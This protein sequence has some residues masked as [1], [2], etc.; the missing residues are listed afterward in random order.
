MY[1]NNSI[2][3]LIEGF[4]FCNLNGIR[5][6]KSEKKVKEEEKEREKKDNSNRGFLQNDRKPIE[7][8]YMLTFL[9]LYLIVILT[10]G[11]LK[12]H[13]IISGSINL[14]GKSAT[15]LSPL[16]LFIIDLFI[17][18]ISGDWDDSSTPYNLSILRI[19]KGPNFNYLLSFLFE[20]MNYNIIEAILL[21][22]KFDKINPNFIFLLQM[23]LLHDFVKIS[24]YL[25][26]L[27]MSFLNYG[28]ITT[29]SFKMNCLYDCK[30]LLK[31]L[32]LT[33]I[34]N[35]EK[36]SFK[37]FDGT[38]KPEIPLILSVKGQLSHLDLRIKRREI[39]QSGCSE[40]MNKDELYKFLNDLYKL[41]INEIGKKI[42]GK[43]KGL[44]SDIA[45]NYNFLRYIMKEKFGVAFF[46]FLKIGWMDITLKE[47]K[48]LLQSNMSENK[49]IY[50]GQLNDSF[51]TPDDI[52]MLRFFVQRH[53][54][55]YALNNP[56]ENS[57]A[58]IIER[59]FTLNLSDVSHRFTE[60]KDFLLGYSICKTNG[61]IGSNV[62]LVNSEVGLQ[63]NPFI[64]WVNSLSSQFIT[65]DHKDI[66]G[67]FYALI[68]F[69]LIFSLIKNWNLKKLCI[70]IPNSINFSNCFLFFLTPRGIFDDFVEYQ[71]FVKKDSNSIKHLKE[72]YLK[73][74][75]IEYRIYKDKLM[76]EHDLKNL[77]LSR[78]QRLR[79][80][81]DFFT[82]HR[83]KTIKNFYNQLESHKEIIQKKFFKDSN[84][85]S[86]KSFLF[87]IESENNVILNKN[88][89]K[90]LNFN[91]DEFNG[92]V[93][94][95][96]NCN[97]EKTT[98]EKIF[99]REVHDPDL[100][101]SLPQA[102]K[103]SSIINNIN[104]KV[105]EKNI[106]LEDIHLGLKNNHFSEKKSLQNWLK[107]N[108]GKIKGKSDFKEAIMIFKNRLSE[109]SKKNIDKFK[110]MQLNL[111]ED[112]SNL[113]GLKSSVLET[114]KE[115]EA[116]GKKNGRTKRLTKEVFDNNL[117]HI[118]SRH[119]DVYKERIMRYQRMERRKGRGLNIKTDLC[120]LKR[121][122]E[123]IKNHVNGNNSNP[124]NN[125]KVNQELW[126]NRYITNVIK[127]LNL[128][129][130]KIGESAKVEEI[131]VHKRFNY[132][133]LNFSRQHHEIQKLYNDKKLNCKKELPYW[134]NCPDK[135]ILSNFL[136]KNNIHL[137]EG[138]VNLIIEENKINFLKQ[139]KEKIMTEI[140]AN[141][142]TKG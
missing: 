83:D 135:E 48:G 122:S 61:N 82:G 115:G 9:L 33:F 50:Y 4:Q 52:S 87:K 81:L 124:N 105:K 112:L 95:E 34:G 118:I 3:N 85:D 32:N 116:E 44:E 78:F 131:K 107:V 31:R 29:D 75:Y 111:R 128:L 98:C 1:D 77:T 73:N 42:L 30:F 38:S 40:V 94:I 19:H 142:Q 90:I 16:V 68:F 8:Y 138:I 37:F 133:T 23:V 79:C 89:I 84:S 120:N 106:Q 101:C 104:K 13:F 36:F 102:L 64:N 108:K 137:S 11:F 53:N 119:Y 12:T 74:G 47:F 6:F 45:I 117:S 103:D 14:A 59:F 27:S 39:L 134:L 2:Y 18:N 22:L 49:F 56:A 99:L 129:K 62:G 125:E 93:E 97:I 46:N 132:Q 54:L 57:Q 25:T 21:S 96:V 91:V 17:Y 5:C 140:E 92:N 41:K 51:M 76:Y 15:I 24:L 136:A 123:I 58:Y 88:D 114:F 80:L 130:K 69:M 65:I 72:S 20:I 110:K 109:K 55:S 26:I 7:L 63:Q 139:L 71:W 127:S 86:R 113:E 141:K 60:M 100:I 66:Q 28:S 126:R 70:N 121:F 67:N 43:N 35:N 10:Y